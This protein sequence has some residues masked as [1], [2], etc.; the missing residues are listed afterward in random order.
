VVLVLFQGVVNTRVSG[1]R[2]VIA[3]ALVSVTSNPR[4]DNSEHATTGAV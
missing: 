2:V 1:Y 3:T 4:I